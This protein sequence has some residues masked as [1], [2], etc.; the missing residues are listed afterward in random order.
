MLAQ[1][2]RESDDPRGAEASLRRAFSAA[3]AGHHDRAAALAAI[4]LVDTV[5]AKLHRVDEG[6]QWAW[7]SE[8]VLRRGKEDEAL[9]AQLQ[10]NRGDVYLAK[11]DYAHA[12]EHY[13][14]A[15]ASWE[16][17]VG[18]QH[19]FVATQLFNLGQVAIGQGTWSRP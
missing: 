16:R 17:V 9:V 13:E 1:L 19:F 2:Q 18:P 4:E 3:Q 15:L 12:G 8:A 5:G 10:E 11:T 7:L 6:L 14:R